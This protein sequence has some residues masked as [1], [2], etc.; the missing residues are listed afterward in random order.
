MG[1][2]RVSADM[3]HRFASN[4]QE[5]GRS[6]RTVQAHLAAV[7]AFSKWLANNDKLPRDPLASVGKPNPKVDRRLIRR[8]LLPDEWNWMRATLAAGTEHHGV[9]AK[10]RLL[11]YWTAIQTG[12]RSGELRS[13]TR[14]N[15]FLDAT[16]PYI[17]CDAGSTKNHRQAKQH[18]GSDLA[19]E[20]AAHVSMKAPSAPVFTMPHRFR[21]AKMLYADLADARRQWLAEVKHDPP[22]RLRREQ[23]DFLS[24]LNHD[25]QRL[26]F[27][28]LRHTCGAW[29]AAQGAHPKVIQVIMRHSSITLTMDTYGHLFPGQ[30][31]DAASSIADLLS[32]KTTDCGSTT[33]VIG[34]S[35]TRPLP[36]ASWPS[37]AN[38][39]V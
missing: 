15:L 17:T 1:A 4:L 16:Q 23:S 34:P 3:V 25:G 36:I 18:I 6:A 35:R 26:D 29:V 19:G 33:R 7:K 11:L 21:V 10:D 14:S 22:E 2:I 31:A 5:Q 20:L 28:A 32:A 12:L 8:M 9:P 39:R 37:G 24:D 38:R 13:L 27:H 30:E